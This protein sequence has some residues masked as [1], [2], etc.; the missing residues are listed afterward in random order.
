ML[1]YRLNITNLP[2]YN[3]GSFLLFKI[4]PSNE[5][6]PCEKIER[7]QEDEFFFE[8][9]SLSDSIL[10]ENEKRT[11]KIKRKIRI[12][13]DRDISSRNVLFIDDE[14]YKVFNIYHFKNK[15]GIPQSDI[16]L[17]E[18]NNPVLVEA[19]RWQKRNLKKYFKN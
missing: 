10:F 12:S 18:Y 7:V 14:Y 4:I 16:T 1:H 17:E 6:F 9:L 5:T 15:D 2:N 8:E 13:Q 11:K 19:K 3:D